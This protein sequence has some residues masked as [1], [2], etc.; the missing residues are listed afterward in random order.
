MS[1]LASNQTKREFCIALFNRQLH[2]NSICPGNHE[3]DYNRGWF[4]MDGRCFH[5]P[6]L[7]SQVDE[8]ME[9]QEYVVYYSP[10]WNTYVLGDPIPPNARI[11]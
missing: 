5:R 2:K 6:E 1:V 9:N 10:V 3:V 8:I 4:Y 7:T 11:L